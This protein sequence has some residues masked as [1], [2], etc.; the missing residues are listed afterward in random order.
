VVKE[1]LGV[2]FDVCNLGE[3]TYFLG[4]EVTRDQEARTLKLT[5]KKLMG[6]LLAR[7]GME[8]AKEKSVP[9]NPGEKVVRDGEPLDREKF[10][11][12]ELVR[13]LLCLSLCTWPDIAQAMGVLARYM[14]D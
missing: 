7:Y 13:S 10:P 11:Y 1:L 2:V 5:Q 14:S 12:N 4:I 9:I 6:E 3:A 8:A